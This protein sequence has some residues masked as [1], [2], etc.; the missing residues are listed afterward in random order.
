MIA[1]VEE[2]AR[3]LVCGKRV[4]ILCTALV[5]AVPMADAVRRYGCDDVLVIGLTRGTGTPPTGAGVTC[6]EVDL[7]TMESVA[8]EIAM[9]ARLV[10]D[11]P[12]VV[13]AAV[14]SFD[15]DRRAVVVISGF[16][17]RAGRFLERSTI[18]G[19]PMAFEQLED[20]TLSRALWTECEIASAPE[21][22]VQC[23]WEPLQGLAAR[24]DSGHGTV[25]SADASAGMNGGAD[26]VFQVRTQA[27]ARAAYDALLPVSHQARIMPFLEGVP[28]SIHG[29]V[30]PDGIAVLR[31]VELLVLRRPDASKFVYGGISTG[32]DPA[33]ADRDEMREV[34][35]R[36]GRH[37][38]QKHAYRGGFGIDGILTKDGFR[39]TELNPRFTGGL[40]RIARGVPDLPMHWLHMLLVDGHDLGVTAAEVETLLVPA[41][42]AQ[43]SGAAYAMSSTTSSLDTESVLVAGDQHHLQVANDATDPV[44][45]LERGPGAHGDLVRF[46]PTEVTPGT[47]L[48]PLAVAA[49]DL[50]DRLWDTGFGV[51]QAAPDV[52]GLDTARPGGSPARPA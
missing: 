8:D 12:A 49:F 22:V 31:P 9:A 17:G 45:T 37:L 40:S 21:G 5:G 19:R 51:L 50:A 11:P 28:C 18:G 38:R 3:D 13:R 7:G 2:A 36:V 48:A 24:L 42:D 47:R 33:P 4:V 41:A 16:A 6:T 39:P 20:K 46:T 1:A 27:Q 30:L 14:E 52:A 43:R 15:P 34:A 10:N 26:L 35:R 44:G 25:W 23:A 29:I 32:W